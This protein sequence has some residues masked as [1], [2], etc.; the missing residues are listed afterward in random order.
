MAA[1]A[2]KGF[3]GEIVMRLKTTLLASAAGAAVLATIPSAQAGSYVS[4]FGGWNRLGNDVSG[5]AGAGTATVTTSISH[6][7]TGG[8]THT[9]TVTFSFGTTFSNSGAK[10]RD[11][12]VLGAA[13][14]GDL[15]WLPGLRGEVELAYRHS[16]LGRASAS[17]VI[18]DTFDAV[19]ISHATGFTTLLTSTLTGTASFASNSGSVRTFTLMA[20]AWYDIDMGS[21]FTPYVGGG[22]GYADNEVKHGLVF[23]GSSGDFAW[24]LG[25]G[26]NYKISD[27]TSIGLGYRYLD[28]GDVTLLMAP[29]LGGPVPSQ[30]YDITSHSVLVNVNFKIG[31]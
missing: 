30:T 23:N 27:G 31:K 7:T 5:V 8:G 19:F 24:Q 14:G 10:G 18:T 15:G 29:R 16:K 4:V 17:A 28:A 3:C 13:V 12:F 25:A 6:P 9:D 26:V 21:N 11:G 20:N 22:V 2:Q 1:A